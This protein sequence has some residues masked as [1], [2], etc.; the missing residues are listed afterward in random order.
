LR[1]GAAREAMRATASS[2]AIGAQGARR[3]CA[4]RAGQRR[5]Y[6]GPYGPRRRRAR[7]QCAAHESGLPPHREA[8]GRPRPAPAPRVPRP[9]SRVTRPVSRVMRHA[10]RV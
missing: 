1:H 10:S 2:A 7:F 5:G 6:R 8:L 3:P 4:D 9:A